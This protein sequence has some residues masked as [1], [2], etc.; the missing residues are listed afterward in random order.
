MLSLRYYGDPILRTKAAPVEKI[1]EELR[2]IAREMLVVMYRENGIGLAGPQVGCLQRLIVVDPEPKEGTSSPLFLVNPIITE[3]A[4]TW[5]AEE[6]C[7][8]LPEIYADVPRAESITVNALNLEGR[9][10]VLTADE[11][12]GRVIQHEIDHLDGILFVDHITSMDRRRIH[13]ALRK[14]ASQRR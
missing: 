2:E 11:W 7:L 1:S 14:L 10:I 12:L 13:V 3:R 5:I 8:S 4:G 6:G 9:E